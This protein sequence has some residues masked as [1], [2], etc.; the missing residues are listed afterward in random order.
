MPR[1]FLPSISSNFSKGLITE[2]TELSF[3]DNAVVEAIDCV[4]DRTGFVKRRA[5]FD[6]EDGYLTTYTPATQTS[7]VFTEFVW[8]AV[9]GDG[10]ISFLVQQH[11]STIVFY[12]ISTSVSVS[13]NKLSFTLNLTTYVPS[14]S[15]LNPAIYPC[16]Y[17]NGRGTLVIVNRAIAP[18]YVIY[19]TTTQDITA[20]DYEILAR[21][22]TGLT[23]DLGL[24]GR[25]TGTVASLKT[26]HPAHYYNLLNQGWGEVGGAALTAWDTA[27]TDMPSNADY[28]ALYRSS[29]TS[30]FDNN[31]VLNQDPLNTPAAKG[32]FILNVTNTDRTAAMAADGFSLTLTT[33]QVLIAASAG[34]VFGSGTRTDRAFNSIYQEVNPCTFTTNTSTVGKNFTG[35][36]K[37]INN[38]IAYGDNTFGFI[39]G[40]NPSIT[41]TLMA[42]QTAPA[43]NTDGTT[44]GTLTFT[45]TADESGGRTIVS[46]DTTTFWNYV[47]IYQ[48]INGSITGFPCVLEELEFYSPGTVSSGVVDNI[49]T[50]E[51]PKTVTFFAGRLFYAGLDALSLNNTI[52]FTQILQKEDQYGQCYQINDPTNE[53]IF[54]LLSSDGGTIVIP[55]MG[56]VRKLFTYQNALL[57]LASN[58]VWMVT[59][60]SSGGFGGGFQANDYFVKKLSS[61]GTSSP[62]SVVDRRGVPIWWAEDGIYTIQYDPNF[63]S[64]NVVNMT[65]K[66]IRSFFLDIPQTNRQYAKGAYDQ[67]LDIVYWVYSSEESPTDPYTYNAVLVF[68]GITQAFYPWTIGESDPT[69]RG[70]VSVQDAARTSLPLIKYTTTY[71]SSGDDVLLYSE[72]NNITSYKD[73]TSAGGINLLLLQSGDHILFQ[74]GSN[75]ELEND[76]NAVEVDY[77]S[78]FT[79]IYKIDGMAQRF[80]EM[81]YIWVFEEMQENASCFVQGI[82]DFAINPNS[83]KYSSYQQVCKTFDGN[84]GLN[85]KRLKIRGRGRS[86]Q[87]KFKSETGKPFQIQGWS[88]YQSIPG[89]P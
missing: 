19:D 84:F 37:Q 2:T 74:D 78:S 25:Y 85:F 62:L 48:N 32:H 16:Q 56:S 7:E 44:L 29:P 39:S 42:K 31:R 38:A 28:V 82:F 40:S 51:R 41:F 45:D 22:F 67:T 36:P 73:W 75:I 54:N 83:G 80:N 89:G 52:F 34:T 26:N 50:P 86:L 13:A 17:A 63:N 70:I 88:L 71:P 46:S 21:D 72:A 79:T 69:V 68:S 1:Q 81:N 87:L 20:V 4:F 35:S 23:D 12:D 3:P 76:S 6:F 77:T 65:F 18:T 27:R 59:G 30:I 14:G 58:G 11:G 24:T 47:W 33:P 60:G 5:G 43:S 55:E 8:T 10:G 64:F 9:A 49:V 15:G 53:N 66:T 61:V 57:I